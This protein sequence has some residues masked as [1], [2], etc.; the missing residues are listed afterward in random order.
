MHAA[1]SVQAACMHAHAYLG[2]LPMHGLVQGYAM[3][4]SQLRAV[5]ARS[6]VPGPPTL[7]LLC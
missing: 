2:T 5:H 1:A 6:T 4:L 7:W 3:F